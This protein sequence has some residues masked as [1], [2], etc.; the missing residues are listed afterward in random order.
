MVMPDTS[1]AAQAMG[2][3]SAEVRKKTLGERKFVLHMREIG[4]LGGRPRKNTPTVDNRDPH[5]ISLNLDSTL[6]E[7]TVEPEGER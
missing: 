4:K 1:K 6:T 2:R 3:R 5:A 7:K